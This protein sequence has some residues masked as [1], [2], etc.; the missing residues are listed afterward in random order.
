MISKFKTIRNLAVFKDFVWDENVL[1]SERNVQ[2]FK[3]INII[4]GR[5]YSGKTTLSRIIRA[6][7]NGKISDKYENPQFE[8]SFQDRSKIT[9]S[10]LTG[11][12]K[13]IRVFNE[14]FVRENLRFI[15]NPDEGINAFGAAILGDNA[16]VQTEID[17]L[18]RKLGKS[19][20]GVESGLYL[21]LKDAEKIVSK[22]KEKLS[23][24]ESSL[25]EKLRKKAIDNPNG[26]KYKFERFGD[27]NYNIVKLK[28][29]IKK[30]TTSFEMIDDDR[31][32]EIDSL[33]KEQVKPNINSIFKSDIDISSISNE[34]RELVTKKIS[35]SN[36]IEQ[37]LKD[38]VL[39]TWVKKGKEL[40]EGK[41][42]RCSFCGNIISTDRWE[43]LKSHYDE[44]SE[45]LEE[46]INSLI[47][48]IEQKIRMIEK[49]LIF[50]VNA[51]YLKFY[52]KINRLELLRGKTINRIKSELI[53]IIKQ[54][55]ARKE[56]LLIAQSFSCVEDNSLR[57]E[58]CWHIYE[59]TR[60]EANAFSNSL[61]NE[62]A[63]A[64][65][66][67]RLNE[68][69][70]FIKT[71]EYEKE[72]EKID[73]LKKSLSAKILIRNEIKEEIDNL[74]IAIKEKEELLN[75][76]AA[77]AQKVNE[78]LN[79]YFG[80]KFLSLEAQEREEYSGDIQFKFEVVRGGNKAHHLSEGERSLIAFCYFIAKLED[81]DTKGT[82]P[83]IWID[84]PISSLD[85]NHIF[86]VY[87]LINSKIVA[88]E[89][90]RQLF[91]STH[92]LDFLKYLKRL[93]ADGDK[94]QRNYFIVYRE[95]EASKISL[96]PKY[97]KENI[98]EFNYL[99][100]QI[101]LCSK[102]KSNDSSQYKSFYNFGNNVRKFLEMFLFY[103]Y[104]DMDNLETKLFKF[105][106]D[107]RQKSSLINRMCNE[108]SH[109]IGLFERGWEPIEAPEMREV[110][111][112]ILEKIKE[113]DKDQYNA[114]IKSIGGTCK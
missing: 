79:S 31:I 23:S 68:V 53:K 94:F 85:S 65:T 11:H 59:K 36:K 44:E 12:K 71:I 40:H 99:F 105:F 69:Y 29:D 75:D 54:L 78:Y 72:L 21:E 58:W 3:H 9:N 32:A 89:T 77:G 112:Y 39:N 34:A 66:L 63:R 2:S 86:F 30:V 96:M 107:N 55:E 114:F 87:S 37:L 56:N 1:D 57:L 62:Q 20:E 47:D 64:K 43:E 45:K 60:I 8:L 98:T 95:D 38:A 17:E 5:N 28:D 22:E 101:Y 61:E 15:V 52:T 50:D 104:P 90:F 26:I 73:G 81:V 48:K 103:K 67:L 41:L 6:L 102:I 111:K 16:I 91:V 33:L 97:L 93:S 70:R 113:N 46:R 108:Y 13:I 74:R 42:D 14:D 4:Y 88:N 10:S 76:E 80:H 110:A 82:N 100:H 18:L 106:G 51:F 7:E 19:K 83:I 24:K 84:D 92:N 109:L 27:Q 49:S 25:E 35:N